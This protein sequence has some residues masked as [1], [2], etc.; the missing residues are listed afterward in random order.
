MFVNMGRRRVGW[1]ILW[2]SAALL[3]S[4]LVSRPA[5]FFKLVSADSS[6]FVFWSDG[7]TPAVGVPI[8]VWDL[9]RRE[10]VF[11]TV[12]DENGAFQLPALAPGRYFVTFDV[13]RLDLDVVSP[14]PYAEQQPHDIIV[15]IPRGV[16][17]ASFAQIYSWLMAGSLSEGALMYQMEKRE[18]IV[19]P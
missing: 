6:G 2:V 17:S 13:I 15:V 10:F 8:R 3:S 19:S 14:I 4:G 18:S 7:K 16:A 11:E 5:Y 9:E 1:C 12:T